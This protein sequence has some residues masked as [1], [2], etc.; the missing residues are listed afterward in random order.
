MRRFVPTAG[1]SIDEWRAVEHKKRPPSGQLA[2]KPNNWGEIKEL[3]GTSQYSKA[4]EI[5][6]RALW[7]SQVSSDS[8]I[9]Q[10]LEAA[11][12]ICLIC[13][14]CQVDIGWHQKVY[15]DARQRENEFK[16]Q[17]EHL[18][19]LLE[20]QSPTLASF[21]SENLKHIS[22]TE[23]WLTITQ[24]LI[25]IFKGKAISPSSPVDISVDKCK[26]TSNEVQPDLSLD[27]NG[28]E[29]SLPSV[30]G[31][32]PPDQAF[33]SLT[34]YCLGPF[35]VYQNDQLINNWP[36]GKG[37][38]IL[39]YMVASCGRPIFKDIVIETFWPNADPEA[40]RKNMYVAIHGLRQAFK[41]SQPDF[42]YILFYDDHY[43]L[44][45]D[46]E[47]WV[48]FEEFTKRFQAGQS[49]ERRGELIEAMK[50]YEAAESLYQGN[51]LEEDLYEDWLIPFREGLQESYL[52]TLD[53]L[54][55]YYFEEKKYGICIQFCQ[56]ILARDNCREDAHRFLMCCFS[57][58][59]QRNLALRQ[60]HVCVE[61]L[62]RELG[63]PPMQ[64][65]TELYHRIYAGE[66]VQSP[67]S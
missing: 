62:R 51:F 66:A 45:P 29:P 60:Y 22:I 59:G 4:E 40:A 37:K 10:L 7:D 54:N 17:L 31:I 64:E 63:V 26:E 50:A 14:Q 42:S 58:Q 47:V 15:E 12:R 20:Q 6:Q 39:K 13:Q 41:S 44:N 49:F 24:R 55:Q 56:K 53:R 30:E 25:H 32:P 27:L 46:L 28:I 65:T 38:A 57:R 36:S 5:I 21:T 3:L 19:D 1:V 18:I 43:F 33:P 8:A 61:T 9:T 35:R 34:I 16:E 48:D 2:V 11:G 23:K 52:I 67:N